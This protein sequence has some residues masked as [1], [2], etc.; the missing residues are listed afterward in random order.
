[1]L[2]S[3]NP[4]NMLLDRTGRGAFDPNP[5]ARG[6]LS[7][8]GGLVQARPAT[9][10]VTETRLPMV[11]LAQAFRRVGHR[12]S[13]RRESLLFARMSTDTHR[14]IGLLPE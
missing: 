13:D 5:L 1:L 7:F 6:P 9:R 11:A 10:V 12:L 14:E 2:S 4:A 8:I 3:S